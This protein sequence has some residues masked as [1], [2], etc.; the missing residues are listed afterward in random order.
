M[1][2]KIP[3]YGTDDYT[4]TYILLRNLQEAPDRFLLNVLFTQKRVYQ[5]ADS[6]EGDPAWPV[7]SRKFI[8]D[9]SQHIKKCIELYYKLSTPSDSKYSDQE[10]VLLEC[11]GR[12]HGYNPPAILLAIYWQEKSSKKRVQILEKFEKLLFCQ[13]LVYR[14]GYSAYQVRTLNSDIYMRYSAGQVGSSELIEFFEK[15]I[16]NIT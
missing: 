6:A 10:K 11:I 8:Y 14:S 7:L 13:N 5:S 2:K 3:Q 16:E 15:S 1:L 12:L 4:S 9:Y